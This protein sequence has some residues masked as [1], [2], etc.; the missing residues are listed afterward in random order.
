MPLARHA[1]QLHSGYGVARDGM[2]EPGQLRLLDALIAVARVDLDLD[3]LLQ[4]IVETAKD[5]CGA[6]FAALGVLGEGGEISDFYSAGGPS[7]M[8]EAI[9][10]IPEGVG[11][12]GELMRDPVPL[13]LNDI[14]EHPLS[15]G[16]PAGHEPMSRF[17]GV[18]L[19]IR[20]EVFGNIYLAEKV[21]GAEFDD[22]DEQL[23]GHLAAVAGASI[24]R[25]RLLADH[26]RRQRMVD[27]ITSVTRTVFEGGSEVA[28]QQVVADE[29][30]SMLRA[31]HAVVALALDAEQVFQAVDSDESGTPVRRVGS[32]PYG[33]A[34]TGQLP[35]EQ[36]RKP[37]AKP[38]HL[39]S[40]DGRETESDGG[41]GA[42]LFCPLVTQGRAIGNIRVENPMGR[43]AFDAG[44]A[45]TLRTF[46]DRAAL[47]FEYARVRNEL[48]SIAVF[49]EQVRIGRDLHDTVIQQLFAAGMGLQAIVGRVGDA[50]AVRQ[51]H[52]SV[53]S[54]DH[55]IVELRTLVF[56]LSN[57]P[58]EGYGLRGA[59]IAAVSELEPALGFV[60]RVRFSGAIDSVRNTFIADQVASVVR[61]ALANVARHASASTATVNVDVG[62]HGLAIEISDDGKGA[63]DYARDGGQ[64]TVN[65]IARATSLGGSADLSRQDPSG[66]RVTWKIPL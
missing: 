66:T 61:E 41:V 7:G 33:E 37:P 46:A 5:V 60:P 52:E 10:R 36:T 59:V 22:M 1:R 2:T 11:I 31:E 26:T 43:N 58:H 53:D 42:S 51:I 48:S 25:A 19:L 13:R 8:A 39:R 40:T 17:L 38:G 50:E 21:G 49:N 15:A 47:A 3:D 16:I 62:K 29:S 64:G 6:K 20:D 56:D 35:P 24:E 34:L 32:V 9:G 54:L 28:I 55:A 23:L 45:E 30:R 14:A 18:P 12:L 63:D 65:M 44:D 27:G 57:K 4:E